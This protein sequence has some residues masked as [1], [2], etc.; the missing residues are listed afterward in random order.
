MKLTEK[1]SS[2]HVT[3]SPQMKE[4]LFAVTQRMSIPTSHFASMALAKAVDEHE[5]SYGIAAPLGAP[6]KRQ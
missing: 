4:R 1:K 3:I 6:K 5:R 2:L